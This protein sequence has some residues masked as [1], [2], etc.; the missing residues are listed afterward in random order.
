[1]PNQRQW[2]LLGQ[3]A[4][5][6]LAIYLIPRYGTTLIAD[7]IWGA[8]ETCLLTFVYQRVGTGSCTGG[9]W[10]IIPEHIQPFSCADGLALPVSE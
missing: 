3:F 5:M 1:M 10:L 7:I 6:G 4:A 8:F 2:Y 9:F